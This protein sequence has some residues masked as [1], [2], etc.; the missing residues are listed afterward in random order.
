MDADEKIRMGNGEPVADREV[1]IT[2]V[3]DAPARLLFLA[4]SRP[5]H[6]MRWFG[7]KGWPLTKCEVDFRVGGQYHFQMT[8]PDSAMSP[9]FGGTY[10]EIVPDRKIV[11]DNGF[12][13]PHSPRFLV[14]VVFE[15]KDG[16]T[17]LIQTTTFDSVATKE[18]FVG[19]G[20]V[21]GTNSGFDNLVELLPVLA[22]EEKALR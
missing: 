7:P 16:R 13:L 5:E 9:P 17:T 4:W 20:F 10:L 6:L 8:G 19:Q 22:A 12:E 1:V 11:Y 15:E 3:F 21:G 2:R 14:S 18:L